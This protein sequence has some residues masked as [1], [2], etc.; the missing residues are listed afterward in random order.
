MAGRVTR[1]AKENMLLL[2]MIV[3]AIVALVVAIAIYD[4]FRNK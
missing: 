2:I 4:H 3:L 1:H